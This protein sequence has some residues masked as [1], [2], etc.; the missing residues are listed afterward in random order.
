MTKP[1]ISKVDFIRLYVA[2]LE[3][4]LAFYRDRL[5]LDLI[6]R[7]EESVGLRLPAD[8]TE[9]VLHTKPQKPEIDLM[10][11][12][13]DKA[14]ADFAEIGGQ[15]LVQAF[16]IQ[17]GRCAVVQDPWGNELVLLDSS[18]GP[19]LTDKDGKVIGNVAPAVSTN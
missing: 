13:A 5:G 4:G 15:V 17:I 10:V 12:D 7:T 3:T 6:W 16:D 19:L 1:L 11:A 9:M 18:K 8:E 2:D 14:A